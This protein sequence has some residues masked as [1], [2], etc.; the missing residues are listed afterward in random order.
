ME[1]HYKQKQMK[2]KA[3]EYLGGMCQDCGIQGSSWIFDFH[4]KV[5]SE[6]EWHWGNR[7]TSNW[8]NLKSELD[9]CELLCANCH[10]LRH[11]KDWLQTLV[12]HHP[13]FD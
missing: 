4:H 12:K 10:R 7:R 13:M 5:P 2:L 9:K 3:I 1:T 11:E 8:E 6:K